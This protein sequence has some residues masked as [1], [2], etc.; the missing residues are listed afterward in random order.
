MCVTSVPAAI[1]DDSADRYEVR[2]QLNIYEHGAATHAAD[3]VDDH[4]PLA[5]I[6]CSKATDD[7]VRHS[8]TCSSIEEEATHHAQKDVVPDTS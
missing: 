6:D 2:N 7:H 8:L 1:R 5:Q 4:A 3:S